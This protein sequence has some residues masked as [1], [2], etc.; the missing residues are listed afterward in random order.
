M[1]NNNLLITR[2][3]GLSKFSSHC[4][5]TLDI[6]EYNYLEIFLSLSATADENKFQV[7]YT[8]MYIFICLYICVCEYII[9]Y[10]SMHI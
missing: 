5:L 2:F 7:I 1:I 8:C 6:L 10:V 3:S 4:P 9:L